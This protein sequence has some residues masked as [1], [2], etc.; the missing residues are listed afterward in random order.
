MPQFPQ[1]GPR[2]AFFP[3]LLSLSDLIH[4]GPQC[5]D[6]LSVPMRGKD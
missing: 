5:L 4:H 1:L 3:R 6:I 2:P